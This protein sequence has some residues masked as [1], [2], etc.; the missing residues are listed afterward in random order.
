MGGV[1]LAQDGPVAAAPQDAA[2]PGTPPPVSGPRRA[3]LVVLALAPV[4][5]LAALEQMTVAT[6]LPTLAGELRAGDRGPWVV[7]VHLLAAAAALPVHGRLGGLYGHKG[8]LQLALVLF[9]AGSAL[10]GRAET[11]DQLLLCRALQGAGAG[12]LLVGAQAVVAGLTPHDARGRI[13]AVTGAVFGLASV[14]GPFVGGRLTDD[15]SWRWCFLVNVPGGLLALTVVTLALRLPRPARRPRLDVLGALFLTAA[16]VCLVLAAGW[17]GGTYA[18]N[19]PVITGL[20]AG[21]LTATVLFL[22]AERFAVEPLV[23][24]RLLKDPVFDAAAVMSLVTGMAL[25]GAAAHLPAYLQLARGLTATGSGLFLLPLTA[26]IV[27]ASVVVGRLVARTGSHRTYAVLGCGLAAGGM[28]LLTRLGADTSPAQFCLWT[29]ALGAGIG[30]VMPVLVLAVQHS[31][32]P[33]DL[34][35][36]VAAGDCLRHLGGAIGA[37]ACGTL[38]TRRLTD[39]LPAGTDTP[40]ARTLTP[41][42][43]H[44]L[45]PAPRHAHATAYAEAL[46]GIFLPL[47]PLLVLGLVL[48][49]FLGR[50]PAATA[51]P[52][53]EP[54]ADALAADATGPDPEPVEAAAPRTD[55][56]DAVPGPRAPL[57]PDTAGPRREP[58]TPEP[59][60]PGGPAGKAPVPPP[61]PAPP[62]RVAEVRGTV[63]RH[64]GT[65]VA[66]AS[67]TLVDATGRH[68][69]RV[70]SG[71]DGRYALRTPAVGAYVL[72]TAA[73]GHPPHALTVTVGA[74]H[75]TADVVLGGAGRVAGRVLTASGTPVAGAAVTVTDVRGRVVATTRSGADGGFLVPDVTAGDHTLAAGAHPFRPAELPVT[76]RPAR[77]T[78]LDIVLRGGSV[79]RGTVRGG[80]GRPVEEARVTLLDL[81]GAVVGTLVTGADG[82]YRFPDLAAGEYTV[83]ATGYP[84]AATVLRVADDGRTDHDVRLSHAE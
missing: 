28:W 76:V 44:A 53:P 71:E 6:A 8:A 50:R 17:S 37:A 81:S 46:P 1:T 67:L 61:A 51:L 20:C 79:L 9:T 80:G 48:A 40:A 25:F 78:R 70:T 10:A 32:R 7:T 23:P 41:D 73:D 24:L 26:G 84:P 52:E 47:V 69:G 4:L 14:A 11:M 13:T 43:T 59:R 58:P 45:P 12:G 22:V 66:R 74:R 68:I 3:R 72:I 39:R 62:L 35:P 38:L 83:V 49:L 75:L 64:D 33:A 60:T 55:L 34:G 29:A 57:P 65:A 21:G 56:Q 30:T 16:S 36:A 27:G 82:S 42:L 31:V 19:S 15:L 63:R 18:W 2:P 54:G 5:L 77:E